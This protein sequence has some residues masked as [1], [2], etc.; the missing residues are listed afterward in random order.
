MTPADR[1]VVT[2]LA[3]ALGLVFGAGSARV[4]YV[5][6]QYRGVRIPGASME[7]SIPAGS[8]LRCDERVP[9][10]LPRGSVVLFVPEAGGDWPGR[11]ELLKRVVALPGETVASRPDGVVEIDGTPLD[12][13]YADRGNGFGAFEPVTLGPD[14]LYVLGDNRDESSDSRINGPIERRWVTAVCS[15]FRDGGRIPGTP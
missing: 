4:S 10:R 8:R 1:R 3:V 2:T 11:V 15:R 5:L 9:G 6:T 7:P 12:E 13:P 14:Q